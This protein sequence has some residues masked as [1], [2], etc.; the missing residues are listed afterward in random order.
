[1]LLLRP[2]SLHDFIALPDIVPSPNTATMSSSAPKPQVPWTI[3][4]GISAV[5]TL[6]CHCTAIELTMKLSPPLLAS[7]TQGK[8]QCVAI[9]C[10]CS[11]CV[12]HGSIAVHPLAK[13]VVF[14]KGTDVSNALP[15]VGDASH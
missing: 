11:H 13:D 15:K 5:Y 10:L 2:T 7:E 1:M 12:K 6:T 3:P 8:E 9:E 4:N 14:T